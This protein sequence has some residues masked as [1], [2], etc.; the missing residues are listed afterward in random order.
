M[1]LRYNESELVVKKMARETKQNDNDTQINKGQLA[2]T[3][4][5]AQEFNSTD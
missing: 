1:K 4:M 3:D 2:V 5:P